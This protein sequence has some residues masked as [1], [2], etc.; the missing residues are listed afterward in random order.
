MELVI[1]GGGFVFEAMNYI[2]KLSSTYI[3]FRKGE[4]I[5]ER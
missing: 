4:E 5:R 2:V 1:E 3:F